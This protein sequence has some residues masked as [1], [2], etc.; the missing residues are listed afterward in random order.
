MSEIAG[1][2]EVDNHD[3]HARSDDGASTSMLS[4]E[5]SPRVASITAALV[6]LQKQRRFCIK[7]Q[8]RGDRSTEAFIATSLGYRNEL[9]E[10]DRTAL[11]KRAAT[12]RRSVEKGGR[13]TTDNQRRN[14]PDAG[15]EATLV[16]AT[17][18][19]MPPACVPII[20]HNAIARKAWD[21]LRNDTEKQMCKLARELPGYTWAKTVKGFGDLGFAIIIGETGALSRYA[22]K[23]RVWKRLGLAV[24]D[25]ERQ[26]RA[27]GA[28]Q[29]AAHGYNPQ[30]RAE[31]W[32][33]ADSMFRHQWRGAKDGAD[34][35]PAGP[36]GV[37]YQLRR[38][39][40]ATRE[41]W[42]AAHQK[43]DAVRVMFK[44][45]VE[46]LWKAWNRDMHMDMAIATENG[47]V[48][49]GSAR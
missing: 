13:P 38:A 37:V 23:E 43:N 19:Q 17:M 21:G 42:S 34:A 14:A 41:G 20:L 35:G 24:I 6:G 30:R 12:I 11:F 39:T 28:E 8:Q 10:A 4:N 27:R 36:F 9:S 32:S 29:A 31:V 46:G 22:T 7:S 26:Q 47:Y 18:A 49:Q 2:L 5:P 44:A 16:L 1:Q 3:Y 33:L 48:G 25:G 40:T 45:V 15:E